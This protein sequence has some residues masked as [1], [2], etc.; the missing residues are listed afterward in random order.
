[1]EPHESLEQR[2]R[3][4]GITQ[5]AHAVDAWRRLRA[6]EGPG[7]TIIDLY[8]LAAR[9]RGLRARDLP[10]EERRTL[11]RTVMPDI[12]PDFE[13]T[14]G[15]E[16][17][18]DL[19][20]IVDYDPTWPERYQAWQR[21]IRAALG[22]VVVRIDH[23]GSTSVPGLPAKAI[24]DVQVSVSDLAKES[25]YVPPL[26]KLGLQL[27]SRDAHHRYF[28]PYPGR[29]RDAHVHVCAAGSDWEAD[30][31]RFRDY[32]RTH[33]EACNRY[34]EAKRAAAA[35]WADDEL[36]YTDDKTEV[37]L[38]ILQSAAEETR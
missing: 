15:S 33:P 34:A 18:G 31:L 27:R 19:I 7:A 1:V 11:A 23:V 30:H 13:T 17:T 10:A 3:A 16:R 4:A 9:P 37:I 26:E 5:T 8:E 6:I 20:A 12:W 29:P 14:D 38:N 35:S 22:A 25:S 32:L 2:L 36:A 21:E 28:W 24:I